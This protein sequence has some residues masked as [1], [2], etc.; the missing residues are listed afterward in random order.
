[1]KE[2]VPFCALSFAE[3]VLSTG[4]V[5]LAAR[6]STG[7][8]LGHAAVTLISQGANVSTFG[9]LWALQYVLLDRALFGR[10][11][12]RGAAG[13]HV[14]GLRKAS[15]DGTRRCGLAGVARWPL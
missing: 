3:L 12:G 11:S 6:W 8:G 7:S 4:A 15:P 2:V 13:V 1:M 10:R 5:S 14:D 9:V